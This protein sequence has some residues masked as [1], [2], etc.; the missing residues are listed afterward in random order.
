MPSV[1]ARAVDAVMKLNGFVRGGLSGASVAIA[2]GGR[3]VFARGYGQRDTGTPDRWQDSFSDYYGAGRGPSAP[4]RPADATADTIYEAGSIS[5]TVVAAAIY[6]L[7]ADGALSVDD[8][9]GRWFPAFAPR[10][11]LTLRNLLQQTSGLPDFND[12]AHIKKYRGKPLGTLID[13]LVHEPPAFA[14]GSR[15]AYSNSNYLLLGRVVELASRRPLPAYLAQRFFTPLGMTRTGFAT[16]ASTSDVALGYTVDA[17]R[18]RVRSYPWD[19]RWS[20]GA[21]GLTTTAPDLARFDAALIDG[22]ILPAASFAA[23]TTPSGARPPLGV[24]PYA[25]ALILDRIGTHRELWHN[26]EIGGFHA[27]HALFP[28]DRIAIVVLTDQQ[29]AAPER[30]IGALLGAVVP[31][32]SFDQVFTKNES[33]GLFAL[34]GCALTAMLAAIIA[35]I[36]R[37]RRWWLCVLVALFALVFGFLLPAFVL[38]PLAFAL[39]LVPAALL[40]FPWS[41]LRMQKKRRCPERGSTDNRPE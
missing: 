37:R 24:G 34:F 15:Y 2:V 7:A 11:E 16:F 40:A 10:P 26:G 25:S 27:M 21:G 29:Q 5:K 1:D 12:W 33:S 28:D 9:V 14:A 4:R 35:G 13:A 19:L 38:V 32:S 6:R 8:K 17:N 20:G 22:R 23:M 31:V 3:V 41:R 18:T 30:L 36:V 39:A